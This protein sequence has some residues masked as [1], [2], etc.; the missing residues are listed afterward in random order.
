MQVETSFM[1]HG[2]KK[3]RQEQERE[4]VS[5]ALVSMALPLDYK[6]PRLINVYTL[7]QLELG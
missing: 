5:E 6:L 2:R 1:R 4:L 7:L 3:S